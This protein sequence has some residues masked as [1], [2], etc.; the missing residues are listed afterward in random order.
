M[1]ILNSSTDHKH[2]KKGIT[3]AA[4]SQKALKNKNDMTVCIVFNTM[5]NSFITSE[6]IITSVFSHLYWATSQVIQFKY[7]IPFQQNE[8]R[9]QSS[10]VVF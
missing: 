7:E 4:I 9:W 1:L 2:W 6:H 8:Y 10:A 3:K 5:H